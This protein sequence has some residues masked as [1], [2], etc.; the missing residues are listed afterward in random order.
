MSKIHIHPATHLLAISSG[1][2]GVGKSTVS[3]NLSLALKALGARVGLFD[4]DIYGPNVPLI[5][6]IH[7]KAPASGYAP[8]FRQKNAPPYIKPFERLGIKL[9]SLGF[10]VAEDQAINPL[11]NEVG[12]LAVQTLHDTLWGDL[13]YLILDMPPGWGELHE[14][15]VERVSV[16]GI[17]GVTTPQ[18][19]SLLDSSRSL[20][21]YRE[22]GV[23]I[24]GL[25]ENM[26]YFVCPNCGESHDIFGQ[27]GQWWTNQLA[28]IP[29]LQ[30]IPLTPEISQTVTQTY[31]DGFIESNQSEAGRIFI[32]LAREISERLN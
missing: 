27:M 26:S 9:M 12:N 18:D 13:D 14:A 30:R 22:L 1:K 23:P 17:V 11:S 21:R 8:V 19:L 2:G 16:D 28:D 31:L 24:L 32:E 10:L 3:V 5:F 15:I 7:R 29:L 25:V 4:A 20:I 6:G